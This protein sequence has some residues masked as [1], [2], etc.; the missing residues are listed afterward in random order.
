M[1]DVECA[2]KEDGF[3]ET[4]TFADDPLRL[5]CGAELASFNVAYKCWGRLNE[6]KSN[7]ILICHA[8]TGDQYVLGTNPIT[9]KEGKKR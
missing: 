3:S 2:Q 1:I 4:V 9:G 7:A 5:D 6:D 8:L